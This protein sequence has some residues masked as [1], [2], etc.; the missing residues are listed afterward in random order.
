MK[1]ENNKISTKENLNNALY[2][3]EKE[4]QE[5]MKLEKACKILS[6]TLKVEVLLTIAIMTVVWGFNGFSN[7]TSNISEY[8]ETSI[9]TKK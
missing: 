3:I 9:V 8:K 1:K 6:N 5:I 2:P 4:D 7:Q